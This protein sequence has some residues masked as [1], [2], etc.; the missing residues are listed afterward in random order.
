MLDLTNLPKSALSDISVSRFF[1]DLSAANSGLVR[2]K[3]YPMLNR[4]SV[5][6]S[7]SESQSS[8]NDLSQSAE[9]YS[10]SSASDPIESFLPLIMT[11]SA[12]KTAPRSIAAIRPRK[13]SVSDSN[14]GT[15]PER[16]AIRPDLRS[17]IAKGFA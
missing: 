7:E 10:N 16:A 15:F 3:V 1:L 5:S 8:S 12:S 11:Y 13:P 4:H 14:S 6:E 17:S 9:S 2:K